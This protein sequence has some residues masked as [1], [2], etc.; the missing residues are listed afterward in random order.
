[1]S[2]PQVAQ[3]WVL[4][5]VEP[6]A[7]GAVQ[8]KTAGDKTFRR[9]DPDQPMLLARVMRAWFPAGHAARWVVGRVRLGRGL[10]VG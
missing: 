1:M 4:L 5:D 8:A 7:A 9:Y 6:V 3:H 10:A 2:K